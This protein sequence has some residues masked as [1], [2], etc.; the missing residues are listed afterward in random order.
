[1]GLELGNLIQKINDSLPE[2]ERV[3]DK[4][5]GGLKWVVQMD[6]DSVVCCF[7]PLIKYIEYKHKK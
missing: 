6:T 5:K 7:H 1:M 3:K 4:Q 2:K